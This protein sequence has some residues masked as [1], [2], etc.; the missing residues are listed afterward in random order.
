MEESIKSNVLDL[1]TV[2]N[3]TTLFL[4]VLG[5][6]QRRSQIIRLVEMVLEK[7]LDDDVRVIL[8]S[9]RLWE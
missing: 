2:G 9:S 5:Q 7:R 4:S 3:I 1:S 6:T 8:D